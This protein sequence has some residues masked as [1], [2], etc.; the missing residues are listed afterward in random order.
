MAD[1]D[2]ASRF[3]NPD[4]AFHVLVDAHRDLDAEASAEFNARLVLL[5]ANHIGDL[6]VLRQAVA[7]ARKAA[8]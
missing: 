2:T 4:A 8:R 1:L 6:D 5:L 7:A 3:D